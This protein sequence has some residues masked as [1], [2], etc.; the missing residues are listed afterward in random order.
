VIPFPTQA[1]ERALA[2]VDFPISK[3]TVAERAGQ[4]EIPLGDDRGRVFLRDILRE[5]PLDEFN[6]LT[7]VTE[8]LG[9]ALGRSSH[10]A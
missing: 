4:E 8:S 3:Q 9:R 1:I 2:D 7:E 5:V 10:A 6:S